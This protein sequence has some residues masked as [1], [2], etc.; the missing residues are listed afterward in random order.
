[1]LKLYVELCKDHYVKVFSG[2][3]SS[4]FLLT[5][6]LSF[7]PRARTLNN[8]RMAHQQILINGN[9]PTNGAHQVQ[10]HYLVN[11]PILSPSPNLPHQNVHV[12]VVKNE[13]QPRYVISRQYMP[14]MANQITIQQ[15][16]QQQQPQPQQQ[17]QQESSIYWLLVE[18]ESNN[19]LNSYALVESKD[20]SGSPPLESLNTGKLVVINLNGKHQRATVVMASSKLNSNFKNLPNILIESLI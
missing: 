14:Q 8:Y 5:E 12:Q 17:I 15:Q 1:M 19:E 20:V 2:G 9:Q 13:V 16:Q 18:V 3:R 11:N 10:H 6:I 7:L 4:F